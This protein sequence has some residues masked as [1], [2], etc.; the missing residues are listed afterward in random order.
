M[1]IILTFMTLMHTSARSEEAKQELAQFQLPGELVK[2]VQ[3][4]ELSDYLMLP[5]LQE[6]VIAA[7]VQNHEFQ[8]FTNVRRYIMLYI[9]QTT[10]QI[11]DKVLSS[12]NPDILV[13]VLTDP[14]LA[15]LFPEVEAYKPIFS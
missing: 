6:T 10:F 7:L 8:K 3:L 12:L 4:F 11:V 9:G 15:Q 14:V 1:Q 13:F 2:L 5:Q